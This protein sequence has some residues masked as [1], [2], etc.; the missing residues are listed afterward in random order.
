VIY[1]EA[2][3]VLNPHYKFID[4]AYLAARHRVLRQGLRDG[5]IEQGVG[6]LMTGQMPNSRTPGGACP[7]R[8]WT[9]P[10]PRS[11]LSPI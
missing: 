11:A 7:K 4:K 6:G 8:L 3:E 9:I 1:P 10:I 2:D 5:D